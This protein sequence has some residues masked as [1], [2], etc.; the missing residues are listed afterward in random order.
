MINPEQSP[1][2]AAEEYIHW[3]EA[4]ISEVEDEASTLE[5]YL[6][7]LQERIKAEGLRR[8]YWVTGVFS[9][10]IGRALKEAMANVAP[11]SAGD[12]CVVLRPGESQEVE[13]LVASLGLP[14][15]RMKEFY[16][17]SFLVLNDTLA[18]DVTPAESDNGAPEL[19]EDRTV[20]SL[21]VGLFNMLKNRS[22]EA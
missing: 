19:I 21:Y 8:L 17:D 16:T 1:E 3:L 14:V 12:F 4:A 6:S 10:E 15:R 22:E 13:A 9:Q 11:G 7:R 5:R 18:L 2:K 20:V